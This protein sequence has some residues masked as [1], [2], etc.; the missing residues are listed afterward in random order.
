MRSGEWKGAARF[1]RKVLGVKHTQTPRVITVDKNAVYPVAMDELKQDKTLKAETELRQSK[2]FNN[3]IEQ[4]HRN[5]KR[6]V[7]PMIG[8]QSLNAV[9][10]TLRGIE[11]MNMIRK[12]QV[13][14][15]NQGDSVSQAEFINKI[16]G[17][18]A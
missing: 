1:F 6:I 11:V 3:I 2:Y 5:V 4:D 9:R 10:R 12:G 18:S 17:V 7:N 13:K 14:G 16:F 8:F 15:I